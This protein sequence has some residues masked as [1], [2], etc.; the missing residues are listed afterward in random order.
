MLL[1]QKLLL[2]TFGVTLVFYGLRNF[3]VDGGAEG[4][5]VLLILCTFGKT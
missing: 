2:M 5:G 1:Y 4:E 3:S